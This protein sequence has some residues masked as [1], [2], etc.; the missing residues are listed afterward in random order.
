MGAK[1]WTILEDREL[2]KRHPH[3]SKGIKRIAKELKRSPEAVRKRLVTLEMERDLGR[4]TEKTILKNI[5]AITNETIK[6]LPA[7]RRL[8][9]QYKEPKSGLKPE[10]WFLLFS[11]LHFGLK[12]NSVEVGGL[13]EYNK[14]IA[15]ERVQYLA[16]TIGDIMRYYPNRPKV[17]FIGFLGDMIDNI[18]LRGNQG[19]LTDAMLVQQIIE[20]VNIISDFVI[21]MTR[22]FPVIRAYGVPGNHPRASRNPTDTHP[23]DNFDNL[24]YAWVQDR[25]KNIPNV[26]IG[27]GFSQHK[28]IEI[29][30]WKFWLEH[31][32]TVRSW[33]GIPFYG[34][35]REKNNIENMASKFNEHIDYVTMG[36]HHV[37]ASF[38]DIFMNGSFI[39]GEQYSVGR[40]RRLQLPTQVLL[41]INATHGV[42][43]RRNILLIDK[44]KELKIEVLKI[45][46]G[47]NVAVSGKNIIIK[48]EERR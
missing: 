8:K 14:D 20:T 18:I 5:I 15:K 42:V 47:E 21:Y 31:G 41:G 16:K 10:T 27:W 29:E 38:Q 11:D 45:P 40:L 48:Q 3:S 44:P 6:Y 30:G 36:H 22:F 26:D 13:G 7:L 39:G 17:L 32:D 1:R 34:A 35:I 28:L 12:V 46:S 2:L 24:I 37:W 25:L 4:R 43:W 23:A 33:M 19:Q 9:L